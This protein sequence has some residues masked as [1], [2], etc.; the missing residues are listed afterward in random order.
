MKE[1]PKRNGNRI[2][3]AVIKLLV[4]LENYKHSTTFNYYH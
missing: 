4:I 3:G 1:N 2:M